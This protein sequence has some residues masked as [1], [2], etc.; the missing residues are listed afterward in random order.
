MSLR[1]TLACFVLLVVGCSSTNSAAPSPVVVQCAPRVGK[2]RWIYTALSGDCGALPSTDVVYVAQPTE[3]D[4]GC[5]GSLTYTKDNCTM[6]FEFR[7]G[8][9]VVETG[10]VDWVTDAS[11]GIGQIDHAHYGPTGFTPLC[12]GKYDV[13][14]LRLPS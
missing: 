13:Y 12:K 5:G 1:P 7:C 8:E 2:F 6:E 11:R 3:P 14:V 10:R 9:R 4:P